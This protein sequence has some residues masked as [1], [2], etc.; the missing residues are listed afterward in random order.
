[1]NLENGELREQMD[2]NFRKEIGEKRYIILVC[3]NYFIR[4]PIYY[5]I[6]FYL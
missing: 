1:M 5:Y 3:L 4:I 2:F 6:Y